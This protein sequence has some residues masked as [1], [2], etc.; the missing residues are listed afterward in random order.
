ML[1]LRSGVFVMADDSSAEL[2]RL[3]DQFS[4][5]GIKPRRELLERA[6]NRLRRLSAKI[7]G[8][9]FPSL[10]AAHDVD[11]VVHETW[12]RLLPALEQTEVQ[13]VEDFFRLAAHKIRQVLLDMV[14]R[15]RRTSVEETLPSNAFDAS[16]Q[17]S[18][19]ARLMMWGEFHQR[20]ANLDDE[21]RQV[22]ELHYYLEI[23]QVQIAQLLK[24]SEKQVSR[25]WIKATNRLT[26]GLAITDGAP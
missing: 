9:S 5:G 17:S 7:L 20:V 10:E 2:Q 23:P 8:Q 25:L 16:G 15:A 4:Q 19:P 18:D 6:V 14:D 24:I 13:T 26:V 1:Q 22:F 3:I 12:M 21:Q 11:S